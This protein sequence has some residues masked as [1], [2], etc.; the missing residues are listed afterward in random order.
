MKESSLAAND[1]GEEAARM[2]VRPSDPRGRRRGFALAHALSMAA[3]AA[4]AVLTG[5]ALWL[6]AGGTASLLIWVVLTDRPWARD[7]LGSLANALTG[8]RIAGCAF[9]P[10]LFPRLAAGPFTLVLFG[11]LATDLVDGEVARRTGRT[12]PFGGRLDLETDAFLTLMMCVLL[13]QAGLVGSWVLIAGL[14]RYVYSGLVALIPARHEEP[15]STV[16]R[17]IAAFLV[18]SLSSSFLLGPRWAPLLAGSGT[19]LVSYSFVRSLVWSYRR[20]PAPRPPVPG[21]G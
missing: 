12:S 14:W 18:L 2:S 15:R 9:L 21:R 8:V 16:G 5:R 17:S 6:G 11:L 19:A 1:E 3:A 13:R 10:V 4:A 20:S 7:E